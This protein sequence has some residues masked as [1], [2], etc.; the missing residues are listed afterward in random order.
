M[1]D[2]QRTFSEIADHYRERILSGALEPGSRLP[3]SEELCGT[4]GVTTTT[5]GQA[6]QALAVERHVC[7]TPRGTFVADEPRWTLTPRDRL[8]RVQR[9]G[10]FLAEGE[11]SIVLAA[12]LTRPPL[13]VAELLDLDEGAQVVR[14]EW[15]AGRGRT[16]TA[17]A[18]T[19]YPATYLA[20]AP[21]LLNTAP[22]LNHTITNKVLEA[23]KRTITHARD[24]MH[25]RTANA[26]EANH[27]GV[28]VG[29]TIMAG[30]HRW[31]DEDGVIEYGEWCLPKLFTVGYEYR[32]N[33]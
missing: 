11:T 8:T 13:H 14:R 21:E 3:S 9:A 6:L 1:A 33:P 17:Y 5:I 19:W 27:L 18:V 28:P 26:R 4:W 22:G 23:T 10:S 16:R 15:V 12:E 25:A 7:M 2:E 30:A 29:S 20:V 31:S 24:D 32:P